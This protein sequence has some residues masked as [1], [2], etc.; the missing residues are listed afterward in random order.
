MICISDIVVPIY[1]HIHNTYTYMYVLYDIYPCYYESWIYGLMSVTN[2]GK[3]I[4]I[5]SSKSIDV[6]V[7]AIIYV[8]VGF[9]V[10]FLKFYLVLFPSS[11]L[12]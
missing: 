9:F 1:T 8:T 4:A 10:S 3:C 5:I 2:F 12:Y 7:E 6:C 11:L